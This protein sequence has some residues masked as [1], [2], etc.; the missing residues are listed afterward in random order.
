MMSKMSELVFAI[1]ED[2]D[3]GILSFSDIADKH[4]VPLSWI[5]EVASEYMEQ[6]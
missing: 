3:A 5:D 6:D 1:Q 2:I 4:N